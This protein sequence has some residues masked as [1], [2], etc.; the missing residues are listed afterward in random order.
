MN[1][2]QEQNNEDTMDVDK[3]NS[4]E[5]QIDEQTIE[6]EDRYK[7]GWSNYSE[8]TNGRFAMLGFLA[9]ILIELISQ[10]SFLNWAGIF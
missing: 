4:E 6:I 3:T 7:F 9:I 2:N 5:I 1:S 10:K 8:I